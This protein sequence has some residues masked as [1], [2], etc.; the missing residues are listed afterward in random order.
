MGGSSDS[1]EPRRTKSS[2]SNGNTNNDTNSTL[3]NSPSTFT[4]FTFSAPVQPIDQSHW[5]IVEWF[6][7]GSNWQVDFAKWIILAIE[8]P[9]ESSEQ[10]NIETGVKII[11]REIEELYS[12][13][14]IPKETYNPCLDII[15]KCKIFRL[16]PDKDKREHLLQMIFNRLQMKYNDAIQIINMLRQISIEQR[17]VLRFMTHQKVQ[18]KIAYLRT[19]LKSHKTTYD[20]ERYHCITNPY[21]D[22]VF[23]Q[24]Q[25]AVLEC[26]NLNA[27]IK[28][29]KASNVE[30][31]ERYS[32][33]FNDHHRVNQ[34][35][36]ELKEKNEKLYNE[37]NDN[38]ILTTKYE[39]LVVTNKELLK[40]KEALKKQGEEIVKE[41]MENHTKMTQDR[42]KMI[43]QLQEEA[44]ELRQEAKSA[45]EEATTYQA[46]LGS[47]TNIRWSDST[48]NNPI[49]LT[50]DIENL[51]HS[52]T[53]FTKVKGKSIKI[54]EDAAKKLLAEYQCKANLDHKEIKNYL[55]AA[56]QRMILETIFYF[57][58]NL[59]K[60]ANHDS[61]SDKLL[62][63]YIVYYTH[64]LIKNTNLLAT[65]REGKDSVTAITPVKIRQQVYA[66]LGSRGFAKPNHPLV[67]HLI[68]KILGKM[69]MYREVIDDGNKNELRSD[70]EKIIRTGLQLW[71]CLKA[72]EPIAKVQWFKAGAHLESHLIVGAWENDNIKEMEVDFAYFP[73][74]MSEH[75]NQVF[76]KAQ[77]FVRPKANGRTKKLFGIF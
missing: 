3:S 32:D 76:S 4:S 20:M 31:N 72:Q 63:S 28:A 2:A 42:D 16:N 23:K 73:L 51:Q 66:A 36:I 65:T 19:T 22:E 30:L 69:E 60:Y 39:K 14:M 50:K 74:I 77:V 70:A 6:G 46:A 59:F 18:A 56:L 67:S 34:E 7:N 45:K 75:D 53:V 58:D 38:K 71:F 54:N 55:A 68:N 52:L 21:Y 57:A 47:A 43:K 41:I 12:A 10:P 33:I 29:V 1:N 40:A 44:K 62:E 64:Y 26:S 24:K 37:V 61:F 5:S 25:A 27:S 49:Q 11:N 35:L 17:S 15:N 48:L 8:E 13:G 9:R